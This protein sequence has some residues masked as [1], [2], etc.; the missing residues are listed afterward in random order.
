MAEELKPCPFCGSDDLCP[1]FHKGE[2]EL[3]V[4]IACD[5]CD[6]EG[7]SV[8]ATDDDNDRTVAIRKARAAWNKRK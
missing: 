2:H 7:P 4:C 3:I 5:A 8:I 1:S 6:V